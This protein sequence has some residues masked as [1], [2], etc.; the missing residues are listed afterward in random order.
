GLPRLLLA[1]PRGQRVVDHLW[2]P[3]ARCMHPVLTDST[4]AMIV[5]HDTPS[6]LTR[7]AL[8]VLAGYRTGGA[9]CRS[10]HARPYRP[11]CHGIPRGGVAY[12]KSGCPTHSDRSE[13]VPS[14]TIGRDA[15]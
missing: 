1:R 12:Q 5:T 10:G 9:A 13:E 8:S 11:R 7:P 4:V 6:R 3:T 15:P 14:A 2:L